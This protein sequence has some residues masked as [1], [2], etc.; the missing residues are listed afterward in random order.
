MLERLATCFIQAS[1][2]RLARL[3]RLGTGVNVV[4]R[5]RQMDELLCV[6]RHRAHT[7]VQPASLQLA[8]TPLACL[9]PARA[10][11]HDVADSPFCKR[12]LLL[13]WAF[14]LFPQHCRLLQPT[15]IIH[16]RKMSGLSRRPQAHTR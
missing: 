13:C 14:S 9:F 11:W 16:W 5:A 6:F 12:A 2:V 4:I 15:S 8:C 1:L 10:R 3:A 7:F